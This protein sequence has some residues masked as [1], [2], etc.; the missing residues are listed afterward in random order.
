MDDR[1]KPGDVDKGDRG[2]PPLPIKGLASKVVSI[3]GNP[4]LPRRGTMQN[5][6]ADPKLFNVID[7]LTKI[8]VPVQPSVNQGPKDSR[9]ADVFQ[10][11]HTVQGSSSTPKS[12]ADSVATSNIQKVNFRSLSSSAV[13]EGCDV[14]LPKESVR[15]VQEKMSNTIYGYF[16]GDRVAFP[17][18]DY[19]VKVN[20]KKYG[21]QKTMMNAN[22][23]FFFKFNDEGR[24]L[25]VLKDG[26]WIIRSQPLFLNT[27]TPT[28]K[29]EKKEVKKVQV[30]VKIHEVPIAA[31]TEDGL[32]LIATTIGEPKMLDSFTTSMCTDSWGR[33][34]Y[35]RALVEISADKEFREEITM[36]IPEPEGEGFIKETMYVEYEW[37]PHRCPTCCVLGHSVEMCPKSPMKNVRQ[38]VPNRNIQKNRQIKKVPNVDRDGYTEVHGKKVAR[39]VGILV[40]KQKNKFEYRPVA[41]KPQPKVNNGSTSLAIKLNNPFDVLN[42]VDSEEGTSKKSSGKGQEDTDDEV[43]EVYNEMD[44]F[45]Q[46]GALKIQSKQ[47]ASTPSQVVADG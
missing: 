28:T 39:K 12:Y 8:T 36:A 25:N 47:G 32:S 26:P 21:L 19:F 31:Y 3:D 7:E 43:E 15:T 22:G 17:V 40:N 44:V 13:H 46:Q 5:S 11:S 1:S 10:G 29:L 38:D 27:W 41:S 6:Q 35:A 18:V 9:A 42:Q 14:V 33:S 16:L 34:S 23:F 37:S 2:K 20:W 30:W 24:M 4:V 45:M